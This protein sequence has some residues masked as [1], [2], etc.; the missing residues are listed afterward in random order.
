[1]ASSSTVVVIGGALSGP[2]AAARAREIDSQARIILLEQGTAIRYVVGGLAYHLSGE[3]RSLQALNRAR[4]REFR[5]VFRIDVRTGV[6]INRLDPDAHVVHLE[7]GK[8][9]YDRLVYAAG[10][11]SIVPAV[12]G[13]DGAAN[14]LRFRTPADLAAIAALLKRGARRAAI[15]SGGYFGVEAADG[16]LRRGCRVTLI[17]REGRIL[18]RHAPAMAATAASALQ[19]ER[20]TIVTKATVS[21]AARNGSR[22]TSLVLS[23]GRRIPTDLVI[24]AA[25]LRPRTDLLRD[26]GA[27]LLA[28]GTVRV[29]ERAATSLPDVFACGVCVSVPQAPT[30]VPI[31]FAQAAMADKTAQ[32]AGTCAAGGE[33]RIGPVLGTAILRAATVT[34]ARTGLAGADAGP[35]GVTIAATASSH[36]PFFPGAEPIAIE[37]TYDRHTGRVLGAEAAGAAGVDKRIDVLATAIAGRLTVEQLAALDLAYAP[38]YSAVRDPVNVAGT[39]AAAARA[40]LPPPW[41][42]AQRLPPEG[43]RHVRAARGGRR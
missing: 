35:D 2:A 6:R 10:A 19:A 4:A 21:Y 25:G 36:E 9:A 31:W 40:G 12:R 39:A 18:S 24:I 11:E 1:M 3:V 17:E 13:F 30:G 7:S 26:A 5:D 29:D 34:V 38:P 20:A 15:V 43:G 16:L 27:R 23:S 28:D 33:A 37:L 14:V 22:V 42:G 32:V 41:T 8:L